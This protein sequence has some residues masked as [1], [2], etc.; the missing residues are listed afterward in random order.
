MQHLNHL[1]LSALGKWLTA[2]AEAVAELYTQQKDE[3]V[4]VFSSFALRIGCKSDFQYVV[5]VSVPKRAGKNTKDLFAELPGKKLV[6]A[7]SPYGERALVMEFSGGITAVCQMHGPRSD[8]WTAC[9]GVLLDRFRKS[10]PEPAVVVPQPLPRAEYDGTPESLKSGFPQFDK[11][12]VRKLRDEEARLSPQDALTAV[13]SAAGK[14]F[15]VHEKGETTGFLLF[16]LPDFPGKAF[17]NVAEALEYFLRRRFARAAYFGERRRMEALV[18]DG[19]KKWG[20]AAEKSRQSL[21]EPVR[22]GELADLLMA[23]LHAIP[24]GADVAEVFDFYRNQPVSIPLN[25]DWSPQENAE[26]LYKKQ[27]ARDGQI[28]IQQALFT[29]ASEKRERFMEL[30][31]EL[32]RAT[33][34]KTLRKLAKSRPELAQSLKPGAEEA[35]PFRRFEMMGYEIWVGKN[36][37]NNDLLFRTAKK[38]DWWLHAKH[39]HGSHVVVTNRRREAKLPPP[40]LEY[41]A[42]LAAF[43]SGRRNESWVEVSYLPRKYARKAKRLPPGKVLLDREETVL[44]TPVRPERG[45]YL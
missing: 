41:A 31:A 30:K 5:P 16:S 20:A 35:L 10:L 2:N 45:D 4:M 11:Y 22:Y 6:S 21:N 12:F 42:G 13:L 25:P 28:K 24:P 18:R 44:A 40:V 36:A 43:F 17:D 9:D 33:N 39:T 37:K 27:K 14:P 8:F 23:H 38:D 32:E 26:R 3:I 34:L 29:E 1:T 7:H 19:L 15:Y